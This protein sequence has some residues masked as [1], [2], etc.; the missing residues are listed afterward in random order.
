MK[1]LY[2]CFSLEGGGGIYEISYMCAAVEIYNHSNALVSSPWPCYYRG[3]LLITELLRQLGARLSAYLPA[4]HLPSVHK[5]TRFT[6]GPLD[7]CH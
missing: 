7:F 3:S 2:I 1:P 4:D 6:K 5:E